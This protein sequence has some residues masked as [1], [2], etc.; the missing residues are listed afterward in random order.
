[1]NDYYR[2]G[3]DILKILFVVIIIL[4][5]P[6]IMIIHNKNVCEE[7]GGTYIFE[8]GNQGSSC[9]YKVEAKR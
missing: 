6:I 3:L 5:I 4:S 7:K 2:T 9:H 1:M 8:F